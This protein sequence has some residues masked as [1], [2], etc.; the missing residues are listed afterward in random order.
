[1]LGEHLPPLTL[2]CKDC[3]GNG[4]P[5]VD[6]PAGLT[7]ALKAAA[8]QGQSAEIAW[9]ASEIDVDVSADVV[10]THWTA[11]CNAEWLLVMESVQQASLQSL[12]YV[13]YSPD[14]K[15]T[16]MFDCCRCLAMAPL[17]SS[18]I[19]IAADRH[20]HCARLLNIS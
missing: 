17:L 13:H 16:L 4:V 8:P 14:Q 9:E 3:H 18:M 7:L 20:W 19:L 2:L 10:C 12:A 15:S 6:V 1:M 5:M 11:T